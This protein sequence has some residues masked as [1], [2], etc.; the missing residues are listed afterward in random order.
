MD[1]WQPVQDHVDE[2]FKGKLQAKRCKASTAVGSSSRKKK[3]RK[4]K[5]KRDG[6]YD[7]RSPYIA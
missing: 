6:D 1:F 3:K 2:H 5:K 7:R 4:K